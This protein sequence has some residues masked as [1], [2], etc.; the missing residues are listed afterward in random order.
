MTDALPPRDRLIVALDFPSVAEAREMVARLGDSVGFYKIGMELVYGGG[1]PLVEQLVAEGKHVFVDLKL[2]DIPNTVERAARRIA[3]LGARFLTVHAYPQTLAAA[4]RGVA[5]SSL[6]V[7]AVT[8]LTSSDDADLAEAGYSLGA[9]DL[10]AKRALQARAA[11]IDGLILSPEEVEATRLLVGPDML[12][13]TPG[14]RPAGADMG[15]QKRVMTP[16]LAIVAG[17]DYLVAGRPVTNAPDPAAAAR[18][19]VAEIASAIEMRG[20]G[21]S[22]SGAKTQDT[23]RTSGPA[24]AA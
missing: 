22:A 16:Y 20:R 17:A 12:L 14:I 19:I 9:R 18:A 13:V 21:N 4:K 2:H 15:D 7:L 8:V 6:Q 5:G 10:V 23:G 3:G 11:G 24:P 1:L